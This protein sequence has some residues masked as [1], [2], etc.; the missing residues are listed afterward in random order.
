MSAGQILSYVLMSS[1][2]GNLGKT[3]FIYS[4]AKLSFIASREYVKTFMCIVDSFLQ[5]VEKHEAKVIPSSCSPSYQYHITIQPFV[6]GKP[7]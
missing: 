1:F 2:A 4:C 3:V 7:L 6:Q 5:K